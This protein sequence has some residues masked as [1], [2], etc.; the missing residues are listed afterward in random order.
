[1]GLSVLVAMAA[2]VTLVGATESPGL[3]AVTVV[4]GFRLRLIA[5]AR[6]RPAING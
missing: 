6:A 2:G 3:I 5:D 1:M 4:R